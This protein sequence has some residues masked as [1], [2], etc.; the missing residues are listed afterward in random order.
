MDASPP[1]SPHAPLFVPHP[2]ALATPTGEGALL[3]APA[4][5]LHALDADP[6]AA[7]AQHHATRSGS[8]EAQVASSLGSVRASSEGAP[9][10]SGGDNAGIGS[11][12][13]GGSSRSIAGVGSGGE[14][15][16]GDG[17]AE[18]GGAGAAGGETSC[19]AA[20][21]GVG[22]AAQPGDAHTRH[23]HAARLA[24]QLGVTADQA[25]AM[26][27]ARPSLARLSPGALQARLEGLGALF[28]GSQ[29]ALLRMA[30]K[31]PALLEAD[32]RQLRQR[33]QALAGALRQP[34]PRVAA[35][36]L[37]QPSLLDLPAA[38]AAARLAGAAAAL[39]MP[40]ARAGAL[41][42]EQPLLL[43][44]D[45]PQLA[46]RLSGIAD[47]V[48][49]PPGEAGAAAAA[50]MVAA[51]PLLLGASPDTLRSKAASLR[52]ALGVTGALAVRALRAAPQLLEL[53]AANAA[54]RARRLRHALGGQQQLVQALRRE[55]G[56]L[57]RAPVALGAKLDSLS[58]LL[59]CDAAAAA[60]AAARRP[61]LLRRSAEALRRS[62]RALSVWRLDA[63]YKAALLRA[64]PGLLRL[65]AA[66][67]HGRC[68]W[69]RAQMLRSG[70]LHAAMRRLPAGVLGALILHLPRAWRRLEY[71]VETKQEGAG[72]LSRAL[73]MPD[74]SFAEAFPEFPQWRGWSERHGSKVR[75][76]GRR[77]RARC[78]GAPVG[79]LH[80]QP[81][82]GQAAPSTSAQQF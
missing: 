4:A 16:S 30:A 14:S 71:L 49:L 10:T 46:A 48:G 80:S 81:C 70:R 20:A 18:G 8:T 35:A 53:S 25:A 55:R 72:R 28:P 69:L 67:V 11:S 22:A 23:P 68:R 61:A 15:S 82:A 50:A 13:S 41:A 56:L 79:R 12:S 74:A 57:L 27:A 54:A 73:R 60:A 45:A 64:H 31:Q 37:R 51:R 63:G 21:S 36:A 6:L 40:A 38:A 76:R 52:A 66:E 29:A 39:R 77:C 78:R 3:A 9:G 44:L 5:S 26:L 1:P 47:A 42:V 59:A 33:V 19:T 34:A 43:A 17:G 62:H 75:A 58:Q 24:R 65:S 2:C 7:L 32:V